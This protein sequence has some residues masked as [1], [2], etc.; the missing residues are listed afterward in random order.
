LQHGR[1]KI[2]REEEECAVP[3]LAAPNFEFSERWQQQYA[4]E[5]EQREELENKMKEAR[6][7][8]LEEENLER[9]ADADWEMQLLRREVEVKEPQL[10]PNYGRTTVEDQEPSHLKEVFI[11]QQQQQQPLQQQQQQRQTY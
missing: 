11:Q 2:K 6:E 10:N 8:L 4:L 5:K 9:L 1:N 3:R 7:N